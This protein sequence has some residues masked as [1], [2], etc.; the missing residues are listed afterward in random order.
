MFSTIKKWVNYVSL[1]ILTVNSRYNSL[2]IT[3]KLKNTFVQNLLLKAK[4]R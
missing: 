2:K 1:K 3:K 4:S